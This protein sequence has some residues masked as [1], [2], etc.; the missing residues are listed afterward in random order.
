MRSSGSL[1]VDNIGELV[2]NAPGAE[3]DPLGLR[4]DAALLIEDGEVAWIGPAR[5]APAADRRI[6]ADGAAVLPGFVDSHA[7]LVFAGDRAAEFAARMSG[8]PYTGGGIRTTVG[9]TRA[10]SDDE[11]R[12]TVGRLRGEAMRQGTTTIEIKSGYGLTVADETRSLRIAAEFTEDTTFLGAHV[13]PAEYADRPDDY[14]GLVCGPMLA[15]AAPY[16]RWIDVFCERGAFDVDHARAILACGQAV[17]LGVR[18]HANQLGPGP[19]VQLGVE[20][21]AASV[22]HCTHLSDADVDALAGSATVATLL[23]G[24]EFS[25]RSPYPD[26]RRLLDAGVTVALATD[27]NPGSSYT[28]SMPFCIA[29]AVREMRMTP[30]EAVWAATAGGAAALRRTDVG[31]L[32]RGARADLI[33]LDAPSHLHL[34]YRPGVPLIRQV[35]HNGVPQCRP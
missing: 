30:A 25:T 16:A 34:A 27:C 20:L 3:G 22:D 21:G 33:I 10:A 4:R 11:L 32:A 29:L 8:E 31:R 26:A 13:V 24:A 9:A 23:P 1:L 6:D 15:A 5:Y 35:L 28:S 7:H 2:T 18:V 17:G 14:V 19:G 12:A